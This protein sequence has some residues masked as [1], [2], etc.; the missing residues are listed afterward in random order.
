MRRL[1]ETVRY[2]GFAA[3]MIVLG[4]AAPPAKQPPSNPV[5]A[6][7]E[8]KSTLAPNVDGVT[9][10][11]TQTAAIAKV[12]AYFNGITH[13]QGRFAQKDPDKKVSKGTIYISRPGKFRFEYSRP[14]RKIIVSDGKYLAIQDLDLKSED[15]YE[16]DNTPFRILLR[17]DV[18]LLRDAKIHNVTELNGEIILTMSDKNPS[19]AG[20]IT[21]LLR[22]LPAVELMGWATTDGQGLRTV[23]QVSELTAPENLEEKLF[24][25]EKLFFKG[26]QQN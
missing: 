17:K 20:T 26:L 5:G 25:R 13:L 24:E 18:N 12:N 6:G 22:S 15:T 1:F 4:A 7:W 2:L 8:T 11:P 19:V 23:V 14:S 10:D 16:L 21:V 9:L 3:L